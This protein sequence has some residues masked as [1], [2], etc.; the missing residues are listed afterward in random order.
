MLLRITDLPP[1]QIEERLKKLGACRYLGNNFYKIS[2]E[3]QKSKILQALRGIPQGET[4]MNPDKKESTPAPRS[5]VGSKFSQTLLLGLNELEQEIQERAQGVLLAIEKSRAQIEQ[6]TKNFQDSAKKKLAE[7]DETVQG[8]LAAQDKKLAE[9]EDKIT[10]ELDTFR[11]TH[12][13]VLE[14]KLNDLELNLAKLSQMIQNL[15]ARE[16]QFEEKVK[17]ACQSLIKS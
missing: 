7:I 1:L 11:V 12:L 6:E 2:T 5:G 17:S 8:K 15:S 16:Q 3:Q 14:K 13:S 10:R 4:E 9:I